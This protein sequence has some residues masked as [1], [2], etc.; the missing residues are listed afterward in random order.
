MPA[1]LDNRLVTSVL[2][3]NKATRWKGAMASF[4]THLKWTGQFSRG[5]IR[6]DEMRMM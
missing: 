4:V 3:K 1:R 5:E 2:T 6:W